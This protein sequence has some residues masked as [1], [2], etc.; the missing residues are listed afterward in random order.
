MCFPL[1]MRNS[2]FREHPSLSCISFYCFFPANKLNSQAENDDALLVEIALM[3]FST[4]ISGTTTIATNCWALW[5]EL[6]DIYQRRVF[7]WQKCRMYIGSVRGRT[8]PWTCT[9][10]SLLHFSASARPLPTPSL[11]FSKSNYNVFATSYTRF[12]VPFNQILKWR[13]FAGEV[14]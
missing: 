2:F 11:F 14:I 13:F 10:N 12:A 4:F 1:I 7:N 8:T 6:K 9:V 5:I 3:T